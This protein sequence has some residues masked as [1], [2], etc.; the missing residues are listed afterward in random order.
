MP[1]TTVSGL[2]R[3]GLRQTRDALDSGEFSAA[4][5][6]AQTRSEIGRL[7]PALRAFISLSYMIQATAQLT[8]PLAGLT[9]SI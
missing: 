2:R 9:F 1:A 3:Y 6:L 8:G 7:E 5:Y 4:E